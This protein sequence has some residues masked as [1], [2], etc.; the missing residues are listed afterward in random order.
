[1]NKYTH[2]HR[3]ITPTFVHMQCQQTTFFLLCSP[4]IVFLWKISA[5]KY[6]LGAFTLLENNTCQ[7]DV[8]TEN[9]ISSVKTHPPSTMTLCQ[10]TGKIWG[11]CTLEIIACRIKVLPPGEF[12]TLSRGIFWMSCTVCLPSASIMFRVKTLCMLCVCSWTRNSR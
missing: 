2:S 8:W 9:V 6:F 1:M 4:A 12:C 5:I 7:V 10:I 11:F 3:L